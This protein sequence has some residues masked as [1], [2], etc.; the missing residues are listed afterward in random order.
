MAREGT[1]A[2]IIPLNESRSLLEEFKEELGIFKEM[3]NGGNSGE[4]LATLRTCRELEG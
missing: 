4:L 2:K 1:D 3:G